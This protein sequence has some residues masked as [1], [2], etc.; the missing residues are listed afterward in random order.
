MSWKEDLVNIRN[1]IR[2][3][4]FTSQTA[5]LAPGRAQANLVMLPKDQALDFLIFCTRNPR[6]CPVLDV[7]EP[8]RWEPNIAPGCD[9][10]TD[11]PKYRIYHNG[12][13]LAEVNDIR[14]YWRAD[15]VSFLIGCSFSFESQLQ[16]AGIAMRHQEQDTIIPVY[17]TNI[18]CKPA[19]P[20]HGPVVVSMRPIPAAR[21]ADAVRITAR[22]P[23]VHGAPL[24]IGAPAA[25]GIDLDKPD[26][27]AP[28]TIKDDET[29]VFWACGVT[30]QAVA[31]A[32]RIPFMIT[33]APAHMFI[34]DL[35]DK[36]LMEP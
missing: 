35:W 7:L 5:G 25:I 33:H 29:P 31:R 34:T 19:G 32:S 20:F 26:W 6:P 23:R 21:V 18:P 27:G 16:A 8:G 28:A 4:Q 10:R 2:Q 30:P 22:L 17:V 11:I 3:N 15:L 9:L 12:G 36:D 14:D 13:M 24:H 1:W